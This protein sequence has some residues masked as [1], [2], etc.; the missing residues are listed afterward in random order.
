M[1]ASGLTYMQAR[2]YDPVIG[3]FLSIDPVG[4]VAS[5]GNPTMFNRY[6][7]VGN[8][9]INK[10]DPFGLEEKEI[11][12]KVFGAGVGSGR[13]SIIGRTRTITVETDLEQGELDTIAEELPD[14]FFERFDGA[15]FSRFDSGL[16]DRIDTDGNPSSTGWEKER[17]KLRIAIQ[18][19]RGV[20]PMEAEYTS[21]GGYA[22]PILYDP[23]NLTG[24]FGHHGRN[25]ILVA[26]RALR[27]GM[28]QLVMTT[29]HERLHYILDTY[30]NR[31]VPEH[32]RL[33]N[34]NKQM[35]GEYGFRG[36]Y[37]CFAKRGDVPCLD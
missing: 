12:R 13:A 4:F 25:Y 28:Q 5:G 7:Y 26:E 37:R 11:S 32:Q 16:P 3:R 15:N 33:Y 22:K 2:Y 10:I 9:P 17:G 29:N 20:N 8:D 24:S 18:I 31:S 19:A 35:L 14:Q 36:N 21:D 6:S 1:N 34:L 23:F 30:G 27:R